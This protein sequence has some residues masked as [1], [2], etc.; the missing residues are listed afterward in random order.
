MNNQIDTLLKAINLASYETYPEEE[1]LI[2]FEHLKLLKDE[3]KKLR[4]E[5]EL[6]K[7]ECKT[8]DAE[9]K[10]LTGKLIEQDLQFKSLDLYM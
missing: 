4:K 9:I 2:K 1:V 8:K 10:N 6:L 7:K 3:I 5:N